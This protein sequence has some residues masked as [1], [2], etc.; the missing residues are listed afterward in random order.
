M[1]QDL[2][3]LYNIFPYFR[4]PNV[5][6]SQPH[7]PVLLL[8]KRL[9]DTGLNA[10]WHNPFFAP[11]LNEQGCGSIYG[12]RIMGGQSPLVELEEY[13][14]QLTL[15]AAGTPLAQQ[16]LRQPTHNIE[17]MKVLATDTG[18]TLWERFATDPATAE[19]ARDL[20]F[21]QRQFPPGA[22][23]ESVM[24]DW[25]RA[26]REHGLR[27]M[28]DLVLNHVSKLHP[29]VIAED[30]LLTESRLHGARFETGDDGLLRRV[31]VNAGTEQEWSFAPLFKRYGNGYPA[32][33]GEQ[34]GKL[35][36]DVVPFHWE[37]PEVRP[38]L[39]EKFHRL[40]EYFMDLGFRGF[41]CDAA[42]HVPGDAWQEI[43][44]HARDYAARVHDA[45]LRFLAET[46]GGKDYEVRRLQGVGFDHSLNSLGFLRPDGKDASHF[47]R[48]AE[49]FLYTEPQ[50]LK[51]I[52]PAVGFTSSHDTATDAQRLMDIGIHQEEA[53]ISAI[54]RQIA[55]VTLL[56]PGGFYYVA[57]SQ[58][59]VRDRMN[60]WDPIIKT[61]AGEPKY[62]LREDGYGG[63]AEGNRHDLTPYIKHIIE[64]RK[65]F[66]VLNQPSDFFVIDIPAMR[67]STNR[68]ASRIINPP[69]TAIQVVDAQGESLLVVIHPGAENT[70]SFSWAA[71]ILDR[72][73]EDIRAVEAGGL[74]LS[75]Y[76]TSGL[77]MQPQIERSSR[78]VH[79]TREPMSTAR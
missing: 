12:A 19:E 33:A 29:W 79:D 38:V 15:Q 58:N 72:P 68:G 13:L 16:H 73:S 18:A 3:F 66:P 67:A 24:R 27:P 47:F 52:G 55:L 21:D 78:P 2:L 22:H 20:R 5:D 49:W 65:S 50:L 32:Y 36:D 53:V 76:C 44:T 14:H 45:D 25:T 6:F 8:F 41:R 77:A 30:T 64:L 71:S 7:D 61:P 11:A 48:E 26:A 42:Y 70:M 35:W 60:V 1:T 40:A 10:T 51:D 39:L 56:S 62:M 75:V 69:M 4:L 37:N 17:W 74:D 31:V 43:I 63:P 23:P 57:G 59:V 46:V 34:D 28:A 9:Q 54:K